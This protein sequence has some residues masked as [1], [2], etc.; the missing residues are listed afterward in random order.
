VN[1]NTLDIPPRSRLYNLEPRGI[2]TPDVESFSGYIARLAEKHSSTL[3]YLF[4]REIAALINKPGAINLRVSFATFAKAT[5]GLGV[6]AAD[7]VKVLERLTLRTDIRFTTM[8]PWFGVISSKGLTRKGR[9]WCPACYE[10]C[11]IQETDVYDQL[12]WSIQC[13]TACV[14][15]KRRLESRCPYCGKQQLILSHRVRPGFCGRCQSWLGEPLSNNSPFNTIQFIAPT[16]EELAVAEEV[17]NLLAAAPTLLSHAV[18]VNFTKNLQRYVERIFMGRGVLSQTHL[19]A[20]KQTI[21][22]WL[23]G[24]Q[25]PSLFLLLK[26][27]LALKISL[28]DLLR[29]DKNGR[30]DYEDDMLAPKKR[31]VNYGVEIRENS[32]VPLLIDWSNK[33]CVTRV[34][35]RLYSALSEDPPA[36]LT[37]IAKELKCTRG[38]LR[39]KFPKLATQIAERAEAYYRPSLNTERI[40]EVLHVALKEY[41]PPPLKEVSRRLGA[42]ASTVTLHKRFPNESRRIVERYSEYG[43]RL[44]D[45]IALEKRLKVALTITP[46]PSMPE[47][48]REVG[49]ARATLHSKFPELTKAISNRFAVARR[50]G[51][52]QRRAR[53]RAEIKSICEQLLRDGLYPDYAM[54]KSQL[55]IPCQSEAYSKIRHEVLVELGGDTFKDS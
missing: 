12:S 6:I 16:G 32:D 23:K 33:E 7:L 51:D 4:S 44:L 34:E 24:T 17:G 42:G 8:L 50:E 19:P 54:V 43:K 37:K 38:T 46:P 47:V 29:D 55:S 11:I 21:S 26:T 53:V 5:N 14:R 40:L 18:A 13:V 25:T 30:A 28:L 39:K 35:R 20:D 10:E 9:A 36:S 1:I 3:Y 15:H 27:C 31:Q 2:G 45:S 48:S 22:C 52:S 41:P 49:V